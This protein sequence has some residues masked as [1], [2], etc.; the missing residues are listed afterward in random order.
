MRDRSLGI[1]DI[2]V[3][4]NRISCTS[5][6]SGA[7]RRDFLKSLAVAGTEAIVSA[8]RLSCCSNSH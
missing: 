2:P 1:N 6:I 3:A 8:N 7:T 4:R 5:P